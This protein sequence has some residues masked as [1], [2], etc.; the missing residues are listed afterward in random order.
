MGTGGNAGSQASA[1]IIRGLALDEVRFKDFWRVVWK[2]LRVSFLLG[3]ILSVACFGKV[4]LVDKLYLA[5]HGT[6][7]ALVICLAM[8]ATIIIAKLI[9]AMLPLLAKVIRLDPAVVASP[10]ITTIVD[11][12]SLTLY[13]AFA[14]AIL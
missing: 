12:L 5:P 14:V 8:L 9:G 7:I 6:W 2:E 10:F 3:A 11:V 1:M 4:M 13:C